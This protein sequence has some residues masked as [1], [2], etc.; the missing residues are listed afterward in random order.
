MNIKYLAHSCFLI[1]SNLGTRIL[2]DPFNDFGG[3]NKPTLSVDV[4]LIS[5]NHPDH[6]NLDIVSGAAEVINGSGKHFTGGVW[7]DGILADHGFI[8]ARWLGQVNCYKFTMDEITCIHMSDIGVLLSDEEVKAIGDVD[9]LFI[10]VG[11]YYT[12]SPEEATILAN[13]MKAKIIIPMHY[14][15]PGMNREKY[16]L[17]NL[18]DF[19]REKKNVRFFRSGEVEINLEN[20]PTEPEIW[21]L[22]PLYL[23]SNSSYSS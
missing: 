18:E 17:K 23:C 7:I 1:T 5:H 3:F 8:D 6:S 22:S 13:K 20:L 11:G 9:V 4:V 15:T 16:P 10:P 21:A 19:I 2:T 14:G 12:I